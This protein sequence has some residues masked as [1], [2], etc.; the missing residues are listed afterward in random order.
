VHRAA[1]A[2]LEKRGY[3]VT[4][5]RMK[6][7]GAAPSCQRNRARRD[8]RSHRARELSSRRQMASPSM[9]RP[10]IFSTMGNMSCRP[11]AAR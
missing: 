7:A 10:R 3:A 11:R 2:V 6:A 9:S 1:R 5:G 4:G 8:A